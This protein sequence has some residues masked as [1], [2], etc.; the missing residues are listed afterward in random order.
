MGA[1]DLIGRTKE[2]KIIYLGPSKGGSFFGWLGASDLI[3]RTRK[4]K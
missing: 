2:R 3:G 1:F 4:G